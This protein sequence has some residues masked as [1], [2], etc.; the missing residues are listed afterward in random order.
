LVSNQVEVYDISKELNEEQK[1]QSKELEGA[2][3]LQKVSV[4]NGIK[5]VDKLSKYD[6]DELKKLEMFVNNVKKF[7]KMVQQDPGVK[8]NQPDT[9][10][11]YDYV[12]VERLVSL[13]DKK[14]E[15]V[16]DGVKVM[17]NF[18]AR[19]QEVVQ[20]YKREQVLPA[21]K[22][23][24][25]PVA[26]KQSADTGQSPATTKRQETGVDIRNKD[27]EL[28]KDEALVT[29]DCLRGE[30]VSGEMSDNGGRNK[31]QTHSV[32]TL[33]L[34]LSVEEKGK[35]LNMEETVKDSVVENVI[36]KDKQFEPVETAPPAK[37]VEKKKVKRNRHFKFK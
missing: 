10:L 31:T 5:V 2:L 26:R 8:L 19:D 28:I 9:I 11:Q 22:A 17:E 23:G 15:A 35:C 21:M 7:P 4:S 24:Q 1:L 27:I 12:K 16:K 34:L 37:V 30:V 14:Q 13:G 3:Q 6:M 18:S 25:P 29:E 20:Q 33:T 36:D 32:Q